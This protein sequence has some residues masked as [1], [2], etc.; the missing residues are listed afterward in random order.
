VKIGTYHSHVEGPWS[1]TQEELGVQLNLHFTHALF[2]LILIALRFVPKLLA[3]YFSLPSV[4]GTGLQYVCSRYMF[5]FAWLVVSTEAWCRANWQ[6][7]SIYFH[8]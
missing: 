8:K 7:V 2:S 1:S 4:L 5:H 6:L 3:R